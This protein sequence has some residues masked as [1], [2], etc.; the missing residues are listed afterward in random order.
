MEGIVQERNIPKK[1]TRKDVAEYAG[2]SVA[3]VSYVFSKKRYVSEELVE[4]VEQAVKALDYVPDRVAGTVGRIRSKNI[5]ILADDIANPLSIEV[6]KGIEHAAFRQGYFVSISSSE[7]DGSR[8]MDE[9][10]AR[11]M[12]GV[13]IFVKNSELLQTYLKRL[14]DKG[15]SVVYNAV[16]NLADERICGMELD[17]YSGVGKIVDYLYSLGHRDIAYLS[18]FD[19]NY[20]F[21][22]R[23]KG[24]HAA[25]KK[26]GLEEKIVMGAPPY[27]STAEAGGEAA[28]RLIG[29]G[30]KFSAVICTNDLMA[31]GALK[32]LTGSGLRIPEDVSLVGMDDILYSKLVQP[33]LT[34]LSHRGIEYGARMFDILLDHMRTGKVRREYFSSELVIRE[35]CRRYG[36]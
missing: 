25:M 22:Q 20:R 12:D 33:P 8:Q 16:N 26:Y 36:G 21:D 6:F 30:M 4:K 9:F 5:A 17:F 11:R 10:I 35:S 15:L 23:L 29:S 31:Y 1:V 18:A 2:V 13:F 3:T 27:L 24:Y 32:T 28:A 7:E 34:T 19:E 14:C